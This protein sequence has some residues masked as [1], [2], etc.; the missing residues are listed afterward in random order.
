MSNRG[1]V[2]AAIAAGFFS[3]GA[4]MA[5]SAAESAT[6]HCQGVNACKGKS[7]CSTAT[8]G[9]AGQNACKGKGWIV[10]SEKDC[11]AKGGTVAK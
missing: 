1:A 7:A 4:P 11:K 2:I 9:C 5:A 6:V 3:A 8:S 10:M